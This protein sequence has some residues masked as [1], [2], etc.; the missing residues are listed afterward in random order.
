MATELKLFGPPRLILDPS[1]SPALA[2]KALG[3]LAY[4]ALERG[5]HPREELAALL[6]G[7]SP[8]EAARTSL[9]QALKQLRHLLGEA[10][11]ISRVT[12]ELTHAVECDVR[13]FTDAAIRS[14]R[15]AI[16]F[17]VPRFLHGFVVRGAPAFE[18]WVT[19]TRR[20]LL[21]SYQQALRTLVLEALAQ[22]RW[23]DGLEMTARWLISDALSEEATRLS[24]EALYLAG[25]RAA[26][27]DHY[28]EF[29]DRLERELGT[30]PGV[31]LAELAKRIEQDIQSGPSP[32]PADPA[33][34]RGPTFNVPL[35][36]REAPWHMLMDAWSACCA[37]E[38]R[39]VVVEGE[40]GIGRTRLAEEFVRWATVKGATVLQGRGYHP[41]SLIPYGPLAE[42][43]QGLVEAPGVAGT[44]AEYLAEAA[45][46]L[47]ELR[48]KFP[49][50]GTTPAPA[51][52]GTSWRLVEG[53]A[54]MILSAA[55]ERPTVVFIDDVQWCDND[56]C[57]ALQLLARRIA[58]ASVIL[59]VTITAGDLDHDIPGSH[60]C[61]VLRLLPQT[62]VAS[63]EPL[64]RD[65]VWQMIRSMGH[66]QLPTE[67]VR[68]ATWLHERTDG[69]PLFLIE[70]IKVLFSTGLLVV[71]P[72]TMEW[73]V[74]AQVGPDA[75]DLV[76]VSR[77]LQDALGRKVM[78][79]P[80]ALRDLLSTIAVG[81]G[82]V[83]IGVLARV[84]G[85]SRIQAA[86][87][88]ESLVKRR[89]IYESGGSYRCTHRVIADMM[90]EGLSPVRRQELHRALALSLEAAA[91]AEM[92]LDMATTMARHA[93]R[94][95]LPA[96]AY[97][98]ALQAAEMLSVQGEPKEALVW[99][100]LATSSA[101]G[102]SERQAVDAA[103]A[104]ILARAGWEERPPSSSSALTD[105][106]MQQEDLDLGVLERRAPAVDTFIGPNRR[107]RT[108]V[109]QN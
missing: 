109:H 33:V 30:R 84:H 104:Q 62:R 76:P 32:S 13:Q 82:G 75:L 45:R 9:R 94:G 25:E 43:L 26:A 56:T 31:R 4:L 97:R 51:D 86:A 106:E 85:V 35:L 92:S 1:S 46:L 100:D 77:S 98:S 55:V 20:S 47:P 23:H 36:G 8:D 72:E 19:T 99:I 67:G 50:L 16:L 44:P 60:L 101:S 83:T 7:E 66:I 11:Q 57:V 14:P 79:L 90:R 37:G 107:R 89:L 88:A 5:A 10:I 73:K 95:G 15:D 81:V 27:L 70:L 103:T 87:L 64:S 12:V 108:P 68:F 91:G 74:P 6:W 102:A 21:Q 78:I 2:A 105:E 61:R 29:S 22:S 54:Q 65:E 52:A 39:V 28:R 59:I 69:V 40:A 58:G 17:D 3:L 80:E 96:L 63:I 24:M 41:Q 53:I 38:G 34:P 49:S 42:A 93:E 48:R 18:E 71:N